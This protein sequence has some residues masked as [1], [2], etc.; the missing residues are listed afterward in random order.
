MSTTI[1]TM[2]LNLY[3][4]RDNRTRWRRRRDTTRAILLT[5]ICYLLGFTLSFIGISMIR[6]ALVHPWIKGTAIFN[7]VE[8]CFTWKTLPKPPCPPKSIS[9]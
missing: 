4:R 1:S 9:R 7:H 3:L 2:S 8:D 5:A 6:F